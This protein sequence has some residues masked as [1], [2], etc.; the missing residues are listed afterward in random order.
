MQRA[1]YGL[2]TAI[3]DLVRGDDVAG[4]YGARVLAL[5]G[6]G[7]NGGDALYAGALLAR[8]GADVEAL[9]LSERAHQAGLAELK[10]SGGRI[11]DLESAHRPDLV[12][13]GIVGIGGKPGL[14]PEA[15][16]AIGRFPDAVVVAVDVPSGVD[17]D[18]GAV[19]GPHVH[20][21][22]TVT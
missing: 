7:D 1:A 16:A 4:V 18:T 2:A 6:S 14:R 21:D 17:V 22:V 8:R 11:V 3:A 15:Q 12:V 19:A 9:L 13:D 5:V 20:A 10:A